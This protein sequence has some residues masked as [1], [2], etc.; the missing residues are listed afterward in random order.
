MTCDFCK[1]KNMAGRIVLGRKSTNWY[2]LVPNDPEVFGHLI[3]TIPG[4]PCIRNIVAMEGKYSAEWKN[5]N[6]GVRA[7]ARK[8]AEISNVDRVYTTFLGESAKVHVHCHLVPRYGFLNQGD[9]DRWSARYGVSKGGIEWRRF[10]SNP[11]SGFCHLQGFRYLGEAERTYNETKELY[12]APP[13]ETLHEI[14]K[15][16]HDMF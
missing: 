11:T 7:C 8:L 13:S 2:A 6:E 10:Y 3:V 1:K 16:I 15:K 4:P 9:L 12:G 14:A 5:L